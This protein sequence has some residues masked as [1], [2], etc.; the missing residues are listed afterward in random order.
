MCMKNKKSLSFLFLSLLICKVCNGYADNRQ[1]YYQYN[2]DKESLSVIPIENKCWRKTT[3]LDDICEKT[4]LMISSD[5]VV[6][7]LILPPKVELHFCGGSIKG[8]IVFNDTYLS[9]TIRLQ[10]SNISGTLKNDVFQTGWICHGNG[11]NDDAQLI[12]QILTMCNT[13]LFNKGTY[14]LSSYHNPRNDLE[15]CYYNSVKSHIGIYKDNV[16][17]IG[18]EGASLLVKDPSV[19]ICVYSKPNDIEHSVKNIRIEGLT[20]RSE[21]DRKDFYEFFHTI[22]M[23]GATDVLVSNCKFFDFWGD[24]I[25]LSHYG[26]TPDTGERTRNSHVGIKDNYIDGGNHNNRNGVSIISGE[27]VVVENNVFVET[28]RNNMP[29]SIDIEANNSAYTVENIVIRNNVIQGCKG[30]VGSI[31]IVSN[32]R[33]APATKIQIKDNIISDTYRGVCFV[34]DSQFSTCDIEVVEN[35][36]S[37]CKNPLILRGKGNS[38][39][40]VI[41]RNNGIKKIK[42]SGEIK[43]RNLK[44]DVKVI[45]R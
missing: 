19:A 44:T 13:V 34:I 26:D 20:F 38:K 42:V 28:S 41:K 31:C 12:N 45:E 3:F 9:G 21:N 33:E 27:Y 25:S 6:D 14:L 11:E 36:F 40:W 37:D 24:A 16:T 10:E 43:V 18:E 22:K 7:S 5:W 8:N 1:T 30:G 2:L 35:I 15:A 23:L 17:L 4:V 39:N 29:G 32:D